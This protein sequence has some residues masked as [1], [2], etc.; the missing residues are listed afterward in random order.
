MR[1]RQIELER[2][3]EEEEIRKSEANE[4][5]DSC[6]SEIDSSEEIKPVQVKRKRGRPKT[7]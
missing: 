1:R 3:K 6:D 2:Y 7:K 4:A 5:Y